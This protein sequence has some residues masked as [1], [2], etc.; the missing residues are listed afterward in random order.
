M[1]PQAGRYRVSSAANIRHTSFIVAPTARTL[2][3]IAFLTFLIASAFPTPGS[4]QNNQQ[5]KQEVTAA[6]TA[7]LAAWSEGNFEALAAQTHSEIRG[8]FFNGTALYRGFDAA[9]LR[10]IFNS[11]FRLRI[12]V[13]ELD[14]QVYGDAAVAVAY[15]D[16]SITVPG[17]DQ[18]IAGSWRYS[19]TRVPVDGTWKVVQYHFSS[20]AGTP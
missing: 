4:G 15:L 6:V 2:T 20:L 3:R 5:A 7:T 19:E 11:G 17:N 18:G 1:T 16:G 14:V 9:A 13:R 10:L 12:T 8:F